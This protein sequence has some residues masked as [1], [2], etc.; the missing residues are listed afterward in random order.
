MFLIWD[1]S[2]RDRFEHLFL[3]HCLVVHTY[4]QACLLDFLHY[5]IVAV[6][7]NPVDF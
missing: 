1:I 7:I 4:L 6:Y 3:S 5:Y 2:S